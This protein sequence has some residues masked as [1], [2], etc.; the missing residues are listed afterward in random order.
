M[1]FITD[2]LGDFGSNLKGNIMDGLGGTAKG[3]FLIP[4]KKSGTKMSELELAKAQD[5]AQKEILKKAEQRLKQDVANTSSATSM[6]SDDYSGGDFFTY[7]VQYNP[8]TITVRTMSGTHRQKKPGMAG[9]TE[10]EDVPMPT[11]T[12][13]TITLVFEAINNSD[14]FIS[15]TDTPS[16][17][18]ANLIGA[19]TNIVNKTLDA[20]KDPEDR[21]S[22]TVRR[23]V[24]G[25]LAL[26]TRTAWRDI[27]FF[28]G[29]SCFHGILMSV[30]PKYKMFNKAGEPI[31]AE[32]EVSMRQGTNSE[33]D[34]KIWED[35]FLNVVN[36]QANE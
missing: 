23:N 10:Y 5:K 9:E 19:G 16:L 20:T 28:Y 7:E 4:S 6:K 15:A 27:T 8:S 12:E 29:R 17:T 18:A 22:Y 33:A 13:F 26:M 24:Q 11:F 36:F 1:D 31:Y 2:K 35:S 34:N 21:N 32:V 3:Y 14:A 30:E 25:F